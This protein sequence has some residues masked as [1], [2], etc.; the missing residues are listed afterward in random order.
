MKHN[1]ISC[2]IITYRMSLILRFTLPNTISQSDFIKSCILLP[3]PKLLYKQA[4][5][6]KYGA[7]SVVFIYASCT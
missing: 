4:S 3:Y 2:N 5:A 1:V 6:T 7:T